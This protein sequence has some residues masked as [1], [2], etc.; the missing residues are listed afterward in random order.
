MFI[1]IDISQ[2]VLYNGGYV[3]TVIELCFTR[4]VT[5]KGNNEEEELSCFCGQVN[6][7]VECTSSQFVADVKDCSDIFVVWY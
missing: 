2:V 7:N 1:R 5:A 4:R 3:I 6:F